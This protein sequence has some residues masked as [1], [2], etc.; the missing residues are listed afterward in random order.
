MSYGNDGSNFQPMSA[1][2]GT[3]L[4]FS[5]NWDGSTKEANMF[6]IPILSRYIRLLPITWNHYVALRWEMLG[7]KTFNL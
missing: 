5:A 6:P 3:H 4:V 1:D 2:D 7:S